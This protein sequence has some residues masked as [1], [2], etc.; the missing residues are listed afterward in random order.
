MASDED[1]SLLVLRMP[2]S[3][4]PPDALDLRDHVCSPFGERPHLSPHLSCSLSHL[5]HFHLSSLPK[6]Q[7]EG[8]LASTGSEWPDPNSSIETSAQNHICGVFW[9]S[10]QMKMNASVLTSVEEPPVTTPWGATSACALPASNTNSSV[11][12]AKTSTNVALLR[13]PAV[14]AVPILRAATCVPV[15]LATSE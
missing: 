15:H 8:Q 13:P 14:M 7:G 9:F 11:E 10:L 1:W 4:T 3:N 6:S 5:S 12:V 2:S